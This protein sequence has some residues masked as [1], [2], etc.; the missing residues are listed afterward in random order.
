MLA[1]RITRLKGKDGRGVIP[2][3]GGGLDTRV[4]ATPEMR[5]VIYSSFLLY[6]GLTHCGFLPTVSYFLFSLLSWTLAFQFVTLLLFSTPCETNIFRPKFHFNR[7]NS[8]E[9]LYI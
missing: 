6:K 1:M 9:H 2:V 5:G 4:L 3:G 8:V 7:P